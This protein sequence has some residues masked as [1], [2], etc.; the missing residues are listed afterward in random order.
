M[1][2]DPLYLQQTPVTVP[3]FSIPFRFLNQGLGYPTAAVNEQDSDVELR[4]CVEAILRYEVGSRP[5]K[6]DFGI[7][8]PTFS[9]PRV[10][11]SE[12]HDQVE[13]W[14][15]RAALHVSEAIS[16][17]DELVSQVLVKVQANQGGGIGG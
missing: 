9:S 17:V 13:R 8:D 2:H 6:P 11:V 5:E 15:P 12:I 1:T 10:N 14:E 3:H 7:E 16:S 4:D